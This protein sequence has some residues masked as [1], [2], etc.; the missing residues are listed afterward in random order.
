MADVL[1]LNFTYEALHVTSLRR[2][3]KLLI[4]N[5]AE[6][7]HTA[8][9]KMVHSPSRSIPLPSMGLVRQ[10]RWMQLKAV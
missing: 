4:Q 3:L 2:A 7:V 6:I 9:G 5:K 8:N 10:Q 1:L